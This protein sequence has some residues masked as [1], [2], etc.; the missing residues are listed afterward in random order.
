V[1]AQCRVCVRKAC[2]AH[3]C[4]AAPLAHAVSAWPAPVCAAGPPRWRVFR[5][6]PSGTFLA[7][8]LFAS[9]RRTVR[10]SGRTSMRLAVHAGRRGVGRGGNAGTKVAG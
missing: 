7:P 5:A 1:T 2:P 9:N 10:A 8:L 6:L 4:T 3:S